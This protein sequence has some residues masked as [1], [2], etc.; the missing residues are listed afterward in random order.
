MRK[1]HKAD[2]EKEISDNKKFKEHI[3]KEN[4]YIY[5]Q[6]IFSLLFL[7]NII[8]FDQRKCNDHSNYKDTHLNKI[9]ANEKISLRVPDS[10]KKNR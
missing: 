2:T 10:N 3:P 6:P 7:P 8:L 5:I 9:L 4:V 1:V